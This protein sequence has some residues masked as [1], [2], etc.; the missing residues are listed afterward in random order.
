MAKEGNVAVDGKIRKDP[1]VPVGFMDVITLLKTNV[2][3]RLLYDVKGR[4]GLNKLGQNESE[5]KF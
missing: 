4:F 3:Y 2:S 5:V 1:R